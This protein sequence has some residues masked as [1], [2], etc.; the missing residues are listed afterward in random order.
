[1]RRVV[2]GG[3][4]RVRAAAAAAAAAAANGEYSLAPP[5]LPFLGRAGCDGRLR[6]LEEW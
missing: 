2:V 5:F 6:C 3:G 1:M 4:E